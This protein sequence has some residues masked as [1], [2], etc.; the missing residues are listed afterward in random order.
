MSRHADFT[1]PMYGRLLDAGLAAGY[2][3]LPVRE[4]V[5]RRAEAAGDG[6]RP[7]RTDER[8]TPDGGTDLPDRFVVLRHDVDRKPRNALAMARIEAEH[9]VRSTY[10]FRTIEKTFRPDLIERIAA[11][12]HEVG[13]HYEDL[14]RADGDP[15]A[16]LSAFERELERLRSL[17]DVETV[18]MHGNPLSAHDN[19][20]VWDHADFDQFDL[21]G[22]A[23]LSM[24]FTDVTYFSDTGR[25]WRDGDLKVKDHTMGEGEKRVQVDSTPE[26][27]GLLL[28]GRIDRA[29]LLSHPNRWAGSRPEWLVEGAKD[30]A[31]NVVK[32]GLALVS[33]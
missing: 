25:T 10:Y 4:Y 24:D 20:D 9:G 12:G 5:V 27:A 16:A 21:L 33:S 14:D 22:E 31:V 3:F 28:S 8:V 11:L 7:E 32:R 19:R 6:S 18:C 1:Y 30:T 13:Y 23:Y 29:C 26:L 17:V 2:E 15:H